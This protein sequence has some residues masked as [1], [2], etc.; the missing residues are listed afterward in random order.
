MVKLASRGRRGRCSHGRIV[1]QLNR[2]TC[3]EE[4]DHLWAQSDA[5][6]RVVSNETDL[7]SEESDHSWDLIQRAGKI[8]ADDPTASFQL[9]LEAAEGGSTWSMVQ[10]GWNYWTGTGVAADPDMALEY[11]HRAISAGSWM[12]TLYYARLLAKLGHH[13]D[14]E[15]TLNG[16][17][18]SGFVPAYFWLGY[19]RYARSKTSLARREV[20]PLME[21]AAAEGHPMAKLFLARWMALGHFGLHNIPRG[22]VSVVRMAIISASA[23]RRAS[24]A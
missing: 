15:S 23:E 11:Y 8:A 7:L 14:C 24:P 10:V 20:R 2:E 5:W 13:D 16:G 21:H 12:A 6:E 3:D 9:Y 18:A 17:L 19:L 22:W 1:S 4:W